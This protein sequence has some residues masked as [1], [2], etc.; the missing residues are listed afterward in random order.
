M[1]KISYFLMALLSLIIGINRVYA[2]SYNGKLYEVWHPDS[3]F[4]VFAEESN[5][6]MD[7]N[8]WMIKSTADDKIYYCI[9]PATPLEGSSSGSHNIYTDKDEIISKT[10]LTEEKYKKV[11]LLAYYG[12]GYKDDYV[13]HTN[14]KWYGITQVMI[15][16]VMRPDLTWTF[17]ESR[18]ATPLA[19]LYASEVTELNTLVNNYYKVP[20]FA[21]KNITVKTGETI[22]LND[23]NKVFHNYTLFQSSNRVELTKNNNKLIVYSEYSS[24]YRI[25]YKIESKTNDVFG[26]L[27]SSDFQDIIR[28]GAPQEQQFYFTLE[29]NGGFLKV[30]KLDLDT[31]LAIPLGDATLKNAEFSIYNTNSELVK[32][33]KTDSNGIAKIGLDYG[34]YILKE[35]KAPTGYKIDE[36]NYSFTLDGNNDNIIINVKNEVIKGTLK[37][38]KTKGGADEKYVFEEDA[39]FEIIDSKGKV[40]STI[41]TDQNGEASISLPYGSYFL[42]Q[43]SGS[44]GYVF[45]DDVIVNIKM[46]KVYEKKIKNVKK[47]ILEFSKTDYPLDIS[48]PNTLIEIYKEDDT[49]IY[50]GKT[51][52]NGKIVLPNLDIGNYYILEKEAPKYYR[53]NTDKMFFEVLENGKVIKA[54]MKNYR[55]EGSLK[56]IKKDSKTNELLEGV[57]FDIYLKGVDKPMF[58]A[59][60]DK[61][62][63]ISIDN[64][65]AGKYCIVETKSLEGYKSSDEKHCIEIDEDGEAVEVI[66]KNDPYTISVPKT[67]AFNIIGVIDSIFI[68]SGSSYFIYEK[69]H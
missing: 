24:P 18:N 40:V 34:N 8:S 49:L 37:I 12:Y 9:D 64:I 25:G 20:S 28:M 35:T 6:Y 58:K 56:I 3:G 44:E 68:L 46:E 23:T 62:G 33:I 67:S 1:R 53:L 47:S 22:T 11:Q 61:N 60:T 48:I 55:K 43:I 45:S 39:S 14:K 69:F 13:D 42:R 4:T 65:I 21:N 30:Q 63:E 52:K 51:D 50:S 7:Y 59:T 5:G 19:S 57:Q 41:T 36:E 17:K 27:V 32:T 38:V 2:S 15:W 31:N 54:N 29:V 66:I 16:R 10:D 26:A